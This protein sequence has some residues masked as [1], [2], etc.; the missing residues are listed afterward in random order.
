M[1]KEQVEGKLEN[2]PSLQIK[3]TK[4]FKNGE[5]TKSISK[6]CTLKGKNEDGII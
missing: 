6:N 2:I 1:I 3:I 4:I 5:K